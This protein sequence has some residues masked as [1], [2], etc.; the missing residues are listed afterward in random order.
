MNRHGMTLVELLL[1]MVLLALFGIAV[2]QTLAS[3]SRVT[4]RALRGLAVARIMVS[5]G[6][7]LRE[8]LGNS[9]A[10]EVRLSGPATV[11][12]SRTVGASVVCEVRGSVILLPASD[13]LGTRSPEAGRDEAV[14]LTDGA[15]GHW[16][17]APIIAVDGGGCPDGS[18]A[19]TVTLT[20]SVG[21][22]GFVRIVEPVHLRGYLAGGSGWWGLAPAD[23]RSPVQPFAGPLNLPSPAITLS[24]AGLVLRFQ[25]SFGSDT[26]L[27]VPLG[28]P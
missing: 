6:A 17:T 13:W 7:L 8:E 2:T 1:G 21:A 24:A 25:P 5:T 10:G 11:D 20:G 9:D 12:F 18:A 22:A 15:S 19:I 23:G 3:T 28:P 26:M 14:L 4:A 16:S 27:R